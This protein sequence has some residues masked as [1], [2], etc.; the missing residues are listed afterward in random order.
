M[1]L[2]LSH[3]TAW[4]GNTFAPGIAGGP[5]LILVPLLV[6]IARV[7]HFLINPEASDLS[8]CSW[9]C[10]AATARLIETAFVMAQG[11]C[12]CIAY[13]FL[14]NEDWEL[15]RNI[16]TN[17]TGLFA[18]ILQESSCMQ[19]ECITYQGEALTHQTSSCHNEFLIY[20]MGYGGD[21]AA[22]ATTAG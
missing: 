15:V 20:C 11:V 18:S 6:A 19:Y 22:S 4:D 10:M 3:E 2:G 13:W 14:V 5:W 17:S 7:L 8:S 21:N 9:C 16:P 12:D 1:I